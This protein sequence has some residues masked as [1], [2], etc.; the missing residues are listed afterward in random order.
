[1]TSDQVKRVETETRGQSNNDSWHQQRVGR[2]TASNFHKFHTKA[3][4]IINR[5]SD[6]DKKPIYSSMV[7]SLLNKSDDV[8]H[9]PQ[10][11]WGNAHEKDAIKSF[12]SD[13]ASQ[14]DGGLQGFRQCGLFIK[15]DYP[16][17]AGSLDGL[18][19]CHCCGLATLEAKCPYSVR[20]ENIHEKKTFDRVEFLEDFNGK[21]RLKRSH[22]YYTQMQAQMWVFVNNITLFYKSFVLPCLLGYR[23]IFECPKCDKVILES[24]EISDSANENSV[25]CDRCSTWWHL[26]CAEL[27]VNSADAL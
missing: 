12:M 24:D 18:F 22:K 25:C 11:K 15:P 27:S 7:S 6:N 26:P 1:M 19:F 16:F 20:N 14:H 23:D 13:V 5:K 10:I 2:V 21:P 3:Q 17:L 4:T 8:S 9:M